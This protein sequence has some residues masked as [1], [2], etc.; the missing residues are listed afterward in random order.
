MARVRH[1]F[2][3]RDGEENEPQNDKPPPDTEKPA[4]ENQGE[5]TP[6]EV[7]ERSRSEGSLETCN[8]PTLIVLHD[9]S[10]AHDTSNSEPGKS[11]SFNE[12]DADIRLDPSQPKS[13][14]APL[15]SQ[16]N[17]AT[18]PDD[19]ISSALSSESGF[20]FGT[21]V[22]PLYQQVSCI[23]DHE[24]TTLCECGNQV[25]ATSTDFSQSLPLT[26]R[27]ETH[28]TDPTD[29]R[30]NKDKV[31]VIKIQETKQDC[32]HKIT[33]IS[34]NEEGGKG[35]MVEESHV[36][37]LKLP[38]ILLDHSSNKS[39]ILKTV[40]EE[41]VV[42]LKSPDSLNPDLSSPIFFTEGL[43][44][45]GEAP[46]C[47]LTND[48]QGESAAGTAQDPLPEH[49]CETSTCETQGRG[50]EQLVW[51]LEI[52]AHTSER[53]ME[54]LESDSGSD[55][56]KSLTFHGK[57]ENENTEAMWRCSPTHSD[58]TV[59]Q[60]KANIKYEET[61][62]NDH[63]K[64]HEIC[65]TQNTSVLYSKVLV[66][67]EENIVS[68]EEE[69]CRALSFTTEDIEKSE[70]NHGEQKEDTEGEMAAE[71]IDTKEMEMETIDSTFIEMIAA[72]GEEDEDKIIL[73]T[74]QGF[75][76]TGGKQI[77]EMLAEKETKG[78]EEGSLES[79]STSEEEKGPTEP[80]I[81]RED[82]EEETESDKENP[83]M[84]TCQ[85]DIERQK[86]L[87]QEDFI[88]K[89]N[90]DDDHKAGGG[91]ENIEETNSKDW[92]E[93]LMDLTTALESML[94]TE[95]KNEVSCPDA[96]VNITDSKAED[97]FSAP[98]HD[99]QHKQESDKENTGE[100]QSANRA[101]E[102]LLDKE[103]AFHSNAN[104]THDLSK[105]GG[106]WPEL[107][108]AEE[109]PRALADE[110]ESGR[111]SPDG[112]SSES[113]SDDEVELY[114]RCLRAVHGGTQAQ[115]D[116]NRDVGSSAA[117]SGNR[118]KLLSTPMPSISESVD[119]E[120]PP[121]WNQDGEEEMVETQTKPAAQPLTSEQRDVSRN[122]SRWGTVN[123]ENVSKTLLYA[124]MLVSFV[125]VAF[126]YD[127]L[128]C[129]GLYIISLIW[130][131]CQGERQPVKNDR[132]E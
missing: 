54:C 103:E 9:A 17:I 117:K 96:R 119:E 122:G 115:K 127:F 41:K 33:E 8:I 10:Q 25:Q 125:F 86:M 55:G 56:L 126:Y 74:S 120:Q 49:I 73:Y 71:N 3:K 105:A 46:V 30:G 1:M 42:D 39:D 48:L 12:G 80:A 52:P 14:S 92:E 7:P 4:Q 40:L 98:A 34:K 69:Q 116:K 112:T 101:N 23:V 110:P 32:S 29:A 109:W 45:G 21:V 95:Q 79:L 81:K 44:L 108:A 18:K 65:Q 6:L 75:E 124:T 102:M 16:K 47:D 11:E 106:D 78:T 87:E 93:D 67:E 111:L 100:E 94:I 19:S 31:L 123:C 129:F 132:F 88:I 104:V 43:N 59:T 36:E 97:G 128:A 60:E 20:I 62:A 58:T 72:A 50:E 63:F 82:E 84:E 66:E 24:K 37:S 51:S 22:A 118:S 5:E 28:G 113:D 13:D 70:E 90:N 26:D 83:P 76:E 131:C 64:H 35:F 130:L 61:D 99:V 38:E 114:M 57:A 2:A 85:L 107:T 68:T 77:G 89:S 53:A 15:H 121:C 91:D 27:I